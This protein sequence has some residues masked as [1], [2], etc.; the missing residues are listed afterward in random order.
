ML[1]G[2]SQAFSLAT[3]FVVSGKSH[4]TLTKAWLHSDSFL[5]LNHLGL[6]IEL[7]SRC[8]ANRSMNVAPGTSVSMPAQDFWVLSTA[9]QHGIYVSTTPAIHHNIHPCIS[10]SEV[11]S[12]TTQVTYQPTAAIEPHP[13]R[14]N[15]IQYPESEPS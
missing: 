7:L 6:N 4:L 1:A 9:E 15:P 3:G 8:K 12:P 10:R 5:F 11:H 2:Y 13:I 14:S